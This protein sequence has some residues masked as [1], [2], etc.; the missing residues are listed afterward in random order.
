MS[1]GNIKIIMFLRSKVQRV[2]RADNLTAIYEAIVE[3][4]GILNISQPYRP[5]STACYGDSFT[6]FL[7]YRSL[8]HKAIENRWLLKQTSVQ[9]NG[10]YSNL[11]GEYSDQTNL[12][13]T[14][15][16]VD[17]CPAYPNYRISETSGIWTDWEKRPNGL[18]TVTTSPKP[19]APPVSI[20]VSY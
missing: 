5:A 10:V 7:L 13:A 17:A 12:G 1:T 20:T 6:F 4:C 15:L 19:C 3:Q 16:H 18:D 14:M 2:S 9:P 8:E 11:V